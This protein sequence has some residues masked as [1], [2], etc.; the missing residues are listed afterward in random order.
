MPMPRM[1]GRYALSRSRGRQ[2]SIW[3]SS[4]TTIACA[5]IFSAR[6]TKLSTSSSDELQYSWN[7]SGPPPPSA[8]TRSIGTDAWLES[9]AGMPRPAA[10]RAI[11]RSASSSTSSRTPTGAASREWG[12][13]ARTGSTPSSRSLTSRSTRGTIRQ[14]SNASALA[15]AVDSRPLDPCTYAHA[16]VDIARSARA[17]RSG[18][19]TGI[20]GSASARACAVDGGLGLATESHGPVGVGH[21][22]HAIT[23]G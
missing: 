7:Q 20:F 9:T 3:V 23:Q 2:P 8:A 13:S 12:R 18:Q 15:S 17:T 6:P 1:N 10:A 5:P 4:V 14:A 22:P 16:S 21:A 19:L 11:A